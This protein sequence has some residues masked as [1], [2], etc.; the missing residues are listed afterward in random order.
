MLLK[1]V[2]RNFRGSLLRSRRNQ[3]VKKV[4]VGKRVYSSEPKKEIPKIERIKQYERKENEVYGKFGFLLDKTYHTLLQ[5]QCN[6]YEHKECIYHLTNNTSWNF[7]EL[8]RHSEA[9][10]TGLFNSKLTVGSAI[11]CLLPNGLEM[12]TNIIATAMCHYNLVP[13]LEKT[14]LTKEILPKYLSSIRPNL[15]VFS[16]EYRAGITDDIY[17]IFALKDKP[18]FQARVGT[19]FGF[20]HTGKTPL[21]GI[22]GF[23]SLHDYDPSKFNINSFVGLDDNSYPY[24]RLYNTVGE[25]MGLN[26]ANAINTGFIVGQHIGMT[27]KDVVCANIPFTLCV[28]QSLGIAMTLAHKARLVIPS[29]AF[30]PKAT[31]AS[32]ARARCTILQGLYSQIEI[33]INDTTVSSFDLSSLS[34]VIISILPSQNMPAPDFISKVK[35]ILRVSTV[36]LTYG[37]DRSGGVIFLEKDYKETGRFSTVLDQC[38]VKGTKKEGHLQFKGFNSDNRAAALYRWQTTEIVGALN[39]D[40]SFTIT[41]ARLYDRDRRR[42]FFDLPSEHEI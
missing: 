3:C 36:L 12:I 38:V 23:R 11:I 26:Q 37:I 33:L 1:F 8:K 15:F 21:E 32:I 35:K 34:K 42:H 18:K 31:L 9:L 29:D 40:K 13:I 20:L 7:W 2:L 39:T 5:E 10:A 17:H 4:I 22:A 16:P 30:D 41:G 24:F 25:F 28:G 14:L 19:I 27:E 6:I